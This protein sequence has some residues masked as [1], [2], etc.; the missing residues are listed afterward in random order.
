MTF[1]PA[2]TADYTTATATAYI[3][4]NRATPTITWATPAGIVYGTALN[5]AQLNA[6]GSVSGT[7]TYNP[8]AGT[9][10]SASISQQ[11]LQVTLTP[12]DTTD[13]T[14]ATG[15]VYIFVSKAIPTVAMGSAGPPSPMVRS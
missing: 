10:L 2:D 8:A 6:T 5:S 11:G 7:M 15:T 3:T 9:V 13:Y 1:T 4:V 12:T 14:T